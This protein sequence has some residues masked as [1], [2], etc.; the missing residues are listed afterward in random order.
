MKAVIPALFISA[1]LASSCSNVK[2]SGG[3]PSTTCAVGSYS[4]A[5]L[6][7]IKQSKFEGITS[8]ELNA[9]ALSLLPCVG[10]PDPE[11]RDGI[12][13]ESLSYLLRK[14]YLSDATKN[15]LTAK[16]I[17]ILE[18][19][20]TKHGFLKPFAAL[21]LSELA[22]ADRIKPYLSAEKRT[23]LVMSATGYL[24]SI[25]DYRGYDDKVGWRHGVAHTADLAL[26]L[27]LNE[28][29]SF[30]R[31]KTLRGAIAKQIAPESGH[32]YIHG[33]SERLARPILY[34]ARRGEFTQQDWDGWFMALT[35]PS[36]FK[37]WGDVFKSEAGLARLHNTKAFLN[38]VYVNAS[39]SDNENIK[40]LQTS[41]LDALKQLP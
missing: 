36:P 22:R 2:F 28:N 20:D 39:A 21:D 6:Q 10:D 1:V 35:A 24:N 12:V 32:A 23:A 38:A 34:M 3:G 40:M 4:K 19:E 17:D 9:F 29:V 27:S 11:M 16:L 31:L 8:D 26:Q 7:R 25:S 14:D 15:E 18:G 33:E 37:A 41:A 5:D 13:Y 30:E